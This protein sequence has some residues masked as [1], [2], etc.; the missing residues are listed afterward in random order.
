VRD[1][2]ASIDKARTL[3]GYHELV[4]FEEGL[5]QTIAYYRHTSAERRRTE[6]RG[7]AR[8]ALLLESS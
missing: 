4:G 8:R 5:R 3:F 1:S 7:V 2:L 6:P